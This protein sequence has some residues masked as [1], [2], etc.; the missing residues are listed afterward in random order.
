[1][2]VAGVGSGA[3]VAALPAT[4]AAARAARPHRLRHRH[5]QRDQ[6]HRRRDRVVD[7]R[8]RLASTGSLEDPDKGHAPLSGYLT[9]WAICAAAALVAAVALLL[10]PRQATSQPSGDG[11][12]TSALQL[13]CILE[14]CQRARTGPK[15][16][17]N[18]VGTSRVPVRRYA[19]T[20]R[21]PRA[22][23]SPSSTPGSTFRSVRRS[24]AATST[25][26][27]APASRSPTSASTTTRTG[28]SRSW[29]SASTSRC[30]HRAWPLRKEDAELDETLDRLNVE[31]DVR[32]HVKDFNERVI[33]A[34]YRLPEGPPL[35]TM[36]RDVDESVAALARPAYGPAWPSSAARPARHS[37][38]NHA[39][40]SG[41]GG[42]GAGRDG[43]G[44][45]IGHTDAD[46]HA[47]TFRA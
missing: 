28:G 2:A 24:S 27:P 46:T 30:C 43:R 36:P 29:S 8:D 44:C 20:G 10:M 16:N 5:D 11:R 1:M 40:P 18:S 19:R 26:C 7:L 13:P 14:G 4:A 35:V 33:A 37:R 9:V 22:P 38:P 23:G 31:A 41:A 25:T 17:Q 47:V 32:R 34:R 21:P 45:Q 12:L 39:K 42:G 3:L 15:G 6:D